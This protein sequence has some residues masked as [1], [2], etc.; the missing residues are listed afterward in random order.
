M[1]QL[2]NPK[3]G[4]INIYEIYDLPEY[5]T[6]NATEQQVEDFLFHLN[7]T[8]LIQWVEFYETYRTQ[9]EQL[10]YIYNG[11][12]TSFVAGRKNTTELDL[13][14]ADR[15]LDIHDK[16][17][18]LTAI[19]KFYG[20]RTRYIPVGVVLHRRDYDRLVKTEFFREIFF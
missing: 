16:D 15:R 8:G 19:R 7:T 4:K 13:F 2:V 11:L 5:V 3:N 14:C 6:L 18:I 9:K 17:A 20:I 1:K 10:E 12:S